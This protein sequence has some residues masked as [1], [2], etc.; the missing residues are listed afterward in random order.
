MKARRKNLIGDT[1]AENDVERILLCRQ[2]PVV[3]RPYVWAFV[4]LYAGVLAFFRTETGRRVAEVLSTA[5]NGTAA[6]TAANGT[7]PVPRYRYNTTGLE[8][9]TSSA[10]PA[11]VV[12]HFPVLLALG[13]V[14]FVQV[15]LVF[16]THWSRAFEFWCNYTPAA[17]PER[18]THAFVTPAPHRGAAGI[19]PLQVLPADAAVRE[20][21]TYF[22]FQR[23]KYVWHRA[24]GL[25]RRVKYPVSLPLAA[26]A[27]R[28]VTTAAGNGACSDD[29][30]AQQEALINAR[31]YGPNRF[32][33]PIP[34]VAALYREQLLA[35]FFV[36]QMLCVLLWCF[37]DQPTMA[38]FTG[39][40]LVVFEG[41]VVLQ[42]RRNLQVLR[43]TIE[44]RPTSVCVLRGAAREWTVLPSDRLLPGDIITV[45]KCDTCPCD[46]LLLQGFCVANESMLTG[47]ST[48]H[49]KEALS[50]VS[51]DLA[52]P[53]A[54]NTTHKGNVVFAGTQ[55]LQASKAFAS[56]SSG[57]SSSESSAAASPAAA[58]GSSTTTTKNNNKGLHLPKSPESGAPAVVLRTGFET[59]QGRLMRTILFAS[60]NVSANN[61]ESF[62]FIAFLLVFAVVASWY[63][64]KVGLEDPTRSRWK[65]FLNC[66]LIV[67]TVVPPELPM[68]LTLAVNNSLLALR[69]LFVFCTEPFRIPLAG[70]LDT[71]C[72][73]K[74]G[75]LTSDDLH[76]LG[77]AAVPRRRAPAPRPTRT[78]AQILAE[79]DVDA[80]AHAEEGASPS[81]TTIVADSEVETETVSEEL[82][83]AEDLPLKAQL[84][85]A[86][87]HS[88]ITVDEKPLGDPVEV[89]ALAAMRW[90]LRH[91]RTVDARH[92]SRGVR[93]LQRYA[94]Q[95]ALRRMATVVGFVDGAGARERLFVVAKGAP[96]VLRAH[97][98]GVPAN[99]DAVCARYASKGGR[100]LALALRELPAGTRVRDLARADAERDLEFVGLA[101][102][103]STIKRDSAAAVQELRHA[104]L[105]V[106]MITGD[107]V[108]TAC[109]VARETHIADKPLF[110]L[111]RRGSSGD[112]SEGDGNGEEQYEWV[113][114]TAS[115]TPERRPFADA[116]T[117]EWDD[118]R[119]L[120]LCVSGDVVGDL[121]EPPCAAMRRAQRTLVAR[122]S[123]FARVSPEQKEGVV[124]LLRATGRGTLMCGDGTN[125]VGALRQA[126][127]G[128]ALLN[129][130]NANELRELRKQEIRD[131][132]RSKH[133]GKDKDHHGSGLS[134]ATR[135]ALEA[136]RQREERERARLRAMNPREAQRVLLQRRQKEL[137]DEMAQ[138][139]VPAVAALGDASIASPFTCRSV[140]VL[141]VL[142]VI[143][144][145]RCT[146]VST[147]QMYRILAVTSLVNAYT[148]SV[149]YFE[150]FKMGGK[151]NTTVNVI[152]ALCFLF[153]SWGKPMPTLSRQRPQA[154][155]FNPSTVL[156]VLLQFAVHLAVIVY[157]VA[158]T[159]RFLPPDYLPDDPDSPFAP[160]LINSSVFLVSCAMQVSSFLV[161]YRGHPFMQSLVENKGLLGSLAAL[162]AAMWLGALE[163]LPNW[164][165]FFELVPFPSSEFRLTLVALMA[166]DLVATF[167]LDRL[168]S[169]IFGK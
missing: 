36:F 113:E 131:A 153:I 138:G 107:N 28:P 162:S 79:D 126:D 20:P 144:Q 45:T 62:L 67:T 108:L 93:V 128:V 41:T 37:N 140:S 150:G 42:R 25:F 1:D 97:C 30:D 43:D 15:L 64:M 8:N 34:S 112:N 26:Y 92:R 139:D 10:P 160:T 159:K 70:R 123:V 167:I 161:N 11:F 9:E 23:V 84:V 166:G 155:L 120:D 106:A 18:A 88:L 130:P 156:S 86:G 121:L 35:P 47:E 169:L 158:Y 59:S 147:H 94:F 163:V 104:S 61:R 101:V 69:K 143:R 68:E 32:E 90:E 39:V 103:G 6:E 58:D 102:F 48:P 71:C 100:V 38:I 82:C 66:T 135:A 53:L 19:A 4:P 151:Q 165:A 105:A 22:E 16:F 2:R 164:N 146:L 46:A 115:E 57:S 44:R 56:S 74:T 78:A 81:P 49:L 77:V 98:R 157:T 91:D 73:D 118:S 124:G 31:L 95:A 149:L 13:A 133:H 24:T 17:T 109:Y 5:A 111:Q 110:V 89:A 52:A 119:N 50:F 76:M 85:L 122:V 137:M 40:M 7:A 12:E 148:M 54:P 21:Q 27:Q 80:G 55:I 136:E 117:R 72:F 99:Y 65:L 127:V 3:L 145:G 132:H 96:E 29:E 87:C 63:V 33:I 60:E 14:A 129:T 134:A 75:T 154:R 125:D 168:I 83:S 142:D 51:G 114:A 141:P 116:L 152:V